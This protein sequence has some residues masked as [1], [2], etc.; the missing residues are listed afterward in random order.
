MPVSESRRTF[1]PH[2]G[3]PSYGY[4]L[5]IA[6]G[7]EE[8]AGEGAEIV[9]FPG[10][11]YAVALSRGVASIGETWHALAT[12]CEQSNWTAAHHQ[13]LEQHLGPISRE[14]DEHELLLDLHL[15]IVAS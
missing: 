9:T 2:P 7:P 1:D 4:E 12:W 11:L 8:E 15:P 5:W 6:V 14:P 3:S 13:W 10:G